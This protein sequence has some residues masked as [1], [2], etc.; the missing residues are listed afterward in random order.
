MDPTEKDQQESGGLDKARL[1]EIARRLKE[2][3][4]HC[5]NDADV[6]DCRETAVDL[7]EAVVADLEASMDRGAG[8][9]ATDDLDLGLATVEEMFRSGNAQGFVR[10]IVSIRGSLTASGEEPNP[11]NELPPPRRF[12]PSPND[13]VRR[14]RPRPKVEAL[15]T[16]EVA[17]AQSGGSGRLILALVVIVAVGVTSVVMLQRRDSAVP[18]PDPVESVAPDR[19][20]EVSMQAL[21]IPTMAPQRPLSED[22]FDYQEEAMAR[23]TLEIRLAEGALADG[24][25]N[26][27][28]RHFATA[29]AIDR[30]HHRVIAM[31]KTLIS[32]FLQEADRAH[33][34]G[35]PELAGKKIESARDLARGLRLDQSSMDSADRKHAA[36]TRFDDISPR[37]SARLRRAVGH[38]VR[39][40][41]KSKDVVFGYLIGLE[42]G[43]L[44]LDVYSGLKGGEAEFSTRILSSTIREIRVYDAQ[45]SSE[46]VTGD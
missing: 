3:R 11:V 40:T 22:D 31:G 46:I 23:F 18:I 41:L 45:R 34:A 8:S 24:D 4:R 19:P 27:S 17:A 37:D 20:A 2:V 32:V 35:N 10:V 38:P 43:F 42:E 14:R 25:L 29:A 33:E 5:F 15:R 21:V 30:H 28:L 9:M 39:L 44:K 13:A 36:L 16:P 7:I 26:E 6:G 12:Q 1:Q